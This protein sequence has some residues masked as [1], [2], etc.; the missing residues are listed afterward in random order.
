M[1]ICRLN[2]D[3]AEEFPSDID[4]QRIISPASRWR[5]G[6]R[7]GIDRARFDHRI[8]A[9]IAQNRRATHRHPPYPPANATIEKGI[10]AKSRALTTHSIGRRLRSGREIRSQP[11]VPRAGFSWIRCRMPAIVKEFSC[12]PPYQNCMYRVKSFCVAVDSGG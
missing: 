4:C 6:F 11:V 9:Q 10:R 1:N 3:Y 12:A 5:A 2:L 7:S 8:A